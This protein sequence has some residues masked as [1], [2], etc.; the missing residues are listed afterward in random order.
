[1]LW[2]EKSN[3]EFVATS[4]VLTFP[5]V[6]KVPL[7]A[8]KVTVVLLCT[9]TLPISV[10]PPPANVYVPL[11]RKMALV[12]VTQALEYDGPALF[13]PQRVVFHAPPL[14]LVAVYICACACGTPKTTISA[15]V[16]QSAAGRSH[17]EIR[18]SPRKRVINPSRSDW[19]GWAGAGL[20]G[21]NS[22][23]EIL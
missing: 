22:K 6:P 23:F 21:P 16:A 12:L 8:V 17:F 10:V 19:T 2:L 5:L 3:T 20:R 1:M 4:I 7:T 15:S 14:V 13:V 18:I 11:E 9:V